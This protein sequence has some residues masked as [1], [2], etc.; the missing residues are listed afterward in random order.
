MPRAQAEA[1]RLGPLID[2]VPTTPTAEQA[3]LTNDREFA[4]ACERDSGTV[5]PFVGT[6]DT[7]RDLDR[8]RAALGDAQLTF[9]G[10]SYGTLLGA[11][12]SQEFPTHV[13]AMALDGAIDPALST[14]QYASEQASSLETELQ[15]FFAW[16]ASTPR[17]AWRPIGDPTAS[18]LA[19]IQQSRTEP[20]AMPD[21]GTAGP[22]R[23]TTPCSPGSSRSHP[24]RRWPVP[25]PRAH[26]ETGRP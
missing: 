16:C 18:L 1:Q 15:S 4:A 11:V 10:H 12:Y 23:S 8:I 20:L 21:G 6:V 14:T 24:G 9:I 19:L 7:A 13:R 26:R 2:P 3:L 17:C 25:S 22:G 5:L